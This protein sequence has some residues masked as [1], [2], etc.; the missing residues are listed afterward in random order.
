MARALT[1]VEHAIIE[2]LLEEPFPGRDELR[3]QITGSRVKPIKEYDDNYGSLE[4]EIRAGPK[5][6]VVE[7]VPVDAVALD[8]DGVPIEFL[9]HVVDGLVRE[10]EV[11]KADGSPIVRR[12]RASDLE[13]SVRKTA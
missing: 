12:P 7:R 11:V 10:L 2:R 3:A 6:A 1:R 4:F 13:V 9:L 5:A 8:V